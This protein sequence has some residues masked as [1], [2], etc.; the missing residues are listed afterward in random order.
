MAYQA[1]YIQPIKYFYLPF[2][3]NE[4]KIPNA[5]DKDKLYYYR[6]RLYELLKERMGRDQWEKIVNG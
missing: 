5:T 2:S 1:E 3:R 4:I 6:V